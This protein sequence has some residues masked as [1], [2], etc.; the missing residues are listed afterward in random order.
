MLDADREDDRARSLRELP[1][2]AA[3]HRGVPVADVVVDGDPAVPRRRDD[4]AVRAARE[5]RHELADRALDRADVVGLDVDRAE[6]AA[7]A[8]GAHL[9]WQHEVARLFAEAEPVVERQCLQ[10][11]VQDQVRRTP[12]SHVVDHG[13]D[14]RAPD[15]FAATA[16]GDVDVADPG[17]MLLEPGGDEADHLAVLFR[18]EEPVGTERALELRPVRIPARVGPGRRGRALGLPALPE[19]LNGLEVVVCAVAD[20][21]AGGNTRSPVRR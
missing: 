7:A 8:D 13:L 12:G 4:A 14:E 10:V 21:H 17:E 18:E 19:P 5:P 3:Q 6:R 2:Q 11:R 1:G 20:G 9:E 16:L 15:S